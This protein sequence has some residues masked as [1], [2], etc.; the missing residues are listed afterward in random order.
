MAPQSAPNLEVTRAR[1]A[2]YLVRVLDLPLT[3]MP[4]PFTDVPE[5]HPDARSITTAYYAGLVQGIGGGEFDP[6]GTLTREQ[7]ITITVRAKGLDEAVQALPTADVNTI[8]SAFSDEATAISSWARPCV[9]LAVQEGLIQG[10][11]DGTM[12]GVRLLNHAE[13]TTMTWRLRY[14]EYCPPEE[15]LRTD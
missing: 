5:T 11:P 1:F 9:A 15:Q 4:S 13:V 14:R 3:D 10:Y 8:L 12:R 2:R 6:E 7:S